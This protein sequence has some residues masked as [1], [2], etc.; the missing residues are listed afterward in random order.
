MPDRLTERFARLAED[1]AGQARPQLATDVRAHGDMRTKRLAATGAVVAG[2]VIA[3]VI[4]MVGLA[5]AGA[6]Q[7]A[8]TYPGGAARPPLLMPHEG[9]PGWTRSDDPDAPGA[10][11]PCGTADVTR[12]GR[13]AAYT[14]TGIAPPDVQSH[15]PTHYLDQLLVYSTVDEAHAVVHQLETAMVHCGWTGG[16]TDETEFG[17]IGFNGF[18]PANRFAPHLTEFRDVMV[19]TRQNAVII[20]YDEITGALMSGPDITAIP[21]IGFNA[22]D[23]LGICDTPTCPT[24]LPVYGTD[25]P[26]SCP[27]GESIAPSGYGG[28]PSGGTAGPT[29][30]FLTDSYPIIS[31][32][33]ADSVT[34]I[35]VPSDSPYLPSYFPTDTSPVTAPGTP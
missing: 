8:T 12:T 1:V 14:M 13:T 35:V 29:G 27:G 24:V 31:G 30:S 7:R 2:L 15:S 34:E 21:L 16:F 3:T 5:P 33:P 28:F 25:G 17:R 11:N 18:Y 19:T 20:I 9:E 10:F 26:Q 22:C 32:S 23:S 4:A 6:A